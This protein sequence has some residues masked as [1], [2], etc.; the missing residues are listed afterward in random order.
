LSQNWL[1]TPPESNVQPLRWTFSPVL[2]GIWRHHASSIGERDSLCPALVRTDYPH[3]AGSRAQPPVTLSLTRKSV[4]PW[5]YFPPLG[6]PRNSILAR[7]V[8]AHS[9]P[10]EDL[11]S[12]WALPRS[13]AILHRTPGLRCSVPFGW[14]AA[15]LSGVVAREGARLRSILPVPPAIRAL[16]PLQS[17]LVRY[18][19]ELAAQPPP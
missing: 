9:Q 5:A 13:V 2:A 17:A 18:L 7:P 1:R 15:S 4:P 16:P 6:L 10:A 11:A 19:R 3:P 12:A 14:P 8:R